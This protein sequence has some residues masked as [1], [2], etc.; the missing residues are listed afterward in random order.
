MYSTQLINVHFWLA[1]IGTVLYIVSMWISGVMQGLMWRAVNSDGTLT[2]S[3]V[4]GLE[5]SYPFYFV[6]FLGGVFFVTGM[7]LMAYNVFKT[8]KAPKESLPALAE[9]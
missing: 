2:Y 8:V 1:T 4:E 5:A 7:L 3:F 9:A 6:R